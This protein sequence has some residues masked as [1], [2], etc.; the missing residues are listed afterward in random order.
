VATLA[1]TGWVQAAT[2]RAAIPYVPPK[3]IYSEWV[4][5]SQYVTVR[6]GTRLAMD[7]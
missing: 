2:S 7:I 3:E 6:D 1:F 5:S 4:R